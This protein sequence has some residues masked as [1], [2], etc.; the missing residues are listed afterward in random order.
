MVTALM[1]VT[2]TLDCSRGS[3][4]NEGVIT[5]TGP[6]LS[7]M[8]GKLNSNEILLMKTGKPAQFL[9]KNIMNL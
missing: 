9:D 1:T 6:S 2:G 3:L 5:I 8:E 4:T 7:A